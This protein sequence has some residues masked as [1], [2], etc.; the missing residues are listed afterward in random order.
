M[1]ESRRRHG[2]PLRCKRTTGPKQLQGGRVLHRERA[3]RKGEPNTDTHTFYDGLLTIPH[4]PMMHLHSLAACNIFSR[5]N[6]VGVIAKRVRWDHGE[7]I[8]YKTSRGRADYRKRLRG[9]VSGYREY[10]LKGDAPSL[11]FALEQGQNVI[12]LHRP[13]D[14]PDELP[15]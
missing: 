10:D 3:A 7:M 14:I 2:I 8:R 5:Q 9:I 6:T 13:L 4:T 12:F 1:E 11:A 15:L